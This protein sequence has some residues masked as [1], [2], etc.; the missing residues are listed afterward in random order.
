[1]WDRCRERGCT[2]SPDPRRLNGGAV[3]ISPALSTTGLWSE[4]SLDRTVVIEVYGQ[5]TA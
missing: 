2:P 3:A 4:N 5:L 1:M